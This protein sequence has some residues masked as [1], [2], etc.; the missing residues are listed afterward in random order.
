MDRFT[1]RAQEAIQAAIEM[2]EKNQNQQVEP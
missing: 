1:L 2:A